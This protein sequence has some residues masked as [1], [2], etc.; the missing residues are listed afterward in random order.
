MRQENKEKLALTILFIVMCVVLF[1]AVSGVFK[2]ARADEWVDLEVSYDVTN[3]L[4]QVDL[5]VGYEF[6]VWKI[7]PFVYLGFEVIT[8]Y[9]E[10]GMFQ[11][12]FIMYP[13]GAGVGFGDFAVGVSHD[14]V[15]L[16]D[17]SARVNYTYGDLNMAGATRLFFRYDSRGKR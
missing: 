5:E 9:A 7:R 13:V 15:H 6:E 11:P 10:R 8:E 3:D 17:E 14:C 4:Q 1:F 2:T 12:Q 16:G